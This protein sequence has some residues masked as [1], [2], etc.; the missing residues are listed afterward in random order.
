MTTAYK[1]TAKGSTDESTSPQKDENGSETNNGNTDAAANGS[2]GN[3][4]KSSSPYYVDENQK[5]TLP[6]AGVLW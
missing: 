5:T 6:R 2:N 3:G 4:S 1:K